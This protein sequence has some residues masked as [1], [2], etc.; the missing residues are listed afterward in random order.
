MAKKLK[1][2]PT[3]VAY[4]HPCPKAKELSESIHFSVSYKEERREEI[5]W[6][7]KGVNITHCPYGCGEL[8]D[9]LPQ[10]VD[11][12]GMEFEQDEGNRAG[13]SVSHPPKK[14]RN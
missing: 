9:L 3:S 10:I 4:K 13:F 12:L 8:P 2:I 5:G 7:F 14:E 1:I 6:Q 11:A